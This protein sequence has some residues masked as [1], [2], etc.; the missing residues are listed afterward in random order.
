[1]CSTCNGY[2]L[3]LLCCTLQQKQLM[4]D[5]KHVQNSTTHKGS[6]VIGL[7]LTTKK[8][9]NYVNTDPLKSYQTSKTC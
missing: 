1:M 5:W 3:L 7:L 9:N 8:Y 6:E 2:K 4:N